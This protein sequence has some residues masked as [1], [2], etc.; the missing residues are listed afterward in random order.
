MGRSPIFHNCYENNSK[1]FPCLR[2]ELPISFKTPGERAYGSVYN[3]MKIHKSIK[4]TP[5]M[6]AGITTYLWSME[7]IVTMTETNC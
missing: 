6:E 7:D 1:L 4:T 3:F 2:G 5:T